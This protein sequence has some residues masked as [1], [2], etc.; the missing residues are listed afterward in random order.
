MGRN[1][2]CLV[3]GLV[4]ARVVPCYRSGSGSGC[5]LLQSLAES[6]NTSDVQGEQFI[7]VVSLLFIYISFV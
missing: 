1:W 7:C 4:M 5:A 3:T 2:L 6:D